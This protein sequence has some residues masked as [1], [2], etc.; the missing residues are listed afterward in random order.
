M[1]WK[2][3]FRQLSGV[4]YLPNRGEYFAHLKTSAPTVTPDE[5]RKIKKQWGEP[6]PE[7]IDYEDLPV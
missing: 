1:N 3:L 4:V 5:M 7:P 6:M 2:R